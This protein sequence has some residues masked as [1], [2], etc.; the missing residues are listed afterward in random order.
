MK[1]IFVFLKKYILQ[2]ILIIIVI[3]IIS[4]IGINL[5]TKPS[6][7]R[8]W[9]DDQK[10]LPF[11]EIHNDTVVIHNIR[12]FSYAST[13]SYTPSY[14]DKIF[15]AN[16]IKK[17]WYIV[18]PFSGV[19]GSAHTFLSFEF[20]NNQFLAISIEIRKEKGESFNPIKGIFNQYE[21]TY[22][23]ADE[24]DVIKLRSNYRK[25]TVYLYPAKGTQEG[26]K[27]LF[28]DML[29][30]ANN[31]KEHPEF[32]NTI[33]NNCTTNIVKHVNKVSSGSIPFFTLQAIFPE[34]SDKLAY[35]LGLIDTTLPFEEARVRYR[36]NDKAIK[37]ADD[38]NFSTKIREE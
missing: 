14:Y 19:P 16:S 12:N 37:Y 38:T 11:A 26:F 2:P 5:I 17:V 30:R 15:N 33:T 9:N 27:L 20:E 18:E 21:L 23:I 36:I 10:I 8:V 35:K 1:K 4:L 32:Y 28:L 31:L 29:T 7:T 3:F 22:V 13:T 24:K 34:Y 6:N 25:D